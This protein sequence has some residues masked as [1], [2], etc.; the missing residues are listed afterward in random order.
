MFEA[1]GPR[2]WT[3][4][5]RALR[6]ERGRRR[7]HAACMIDQHLVAALDDA[8]L[9]SPRS[10]RPRGLP[11]ETYGADGTPKRATLAGS[12]AERCRPSSRRPSRTAIAA[13]SRAWHRGLTILRQFFFQLLS[14]LTSLRRR[15]EEAR[16]RNPRTRHG[17]VRLHPPGG[18]GRERE[19]GQY[20]PRRARGVIANAFSNNGIWT[21]PPSRRSAPNRRCSGIRQGEQGRYRFLAMRAPLRSRVQ[22]SSKSSAPSPARLR[23]RRTPAATDDRADA[24]LC[25]DH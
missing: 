18:L 16:R 9:R 21:S 10:A 25:L 8:Q 15:P 6:P 12:G 13:G 11:A 1:G 14:A 7:H 3:S 5:V 22:R 20:A 2:P 17:D 24:R 19:L 23:R 4:D